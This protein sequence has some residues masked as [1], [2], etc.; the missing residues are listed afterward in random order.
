MKQ[1]TVLS[2][3]GGVGKSSIT[4][5]FAVVLSKKIK[6]LC[7]DCDVD[8][9][10]LGLVLG[11]RENDF[12][13]WNKI[14][15][16]K[17]AVIDNEK[18]ISCKLCIENCYFGAIEQR[19]NKIVVKEFGCEGCGVC[20]LV[21]PNNAVKLKDVQNGKIGTGK[22]KYGFE[23]ISGT[24]AA[25]ESGSGKIVHEIRKLASKKEN[26]DLILND[27]PAGIGCPV[28]A[29]VA[30]ANYCVIVTEPTPS[31]FSD[32]KRAFGMVSHFRIKSGLI[33]NKY[34]LNEAFTQEIEEYAKK[35]GIELIGKIQYDKSFLYAL[36]NLTPVVEYNK[37]TMPAF[38]AIAE[39]IE[40]NIK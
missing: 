4:A 15:T 35:Q 1:I 25:G 21:C 33:I 24:L 19:D 39:K 12:L 5:S 13:S 17:K 16:S 23:I 9:S 8:A 29:S 14:S 11:L 6:V 26:I 32:F 2:G 7:V 30:G 31:G 34:D 38:K 10:N 27:A 3:K 37:K 28:I 40:L 22:T 20:E 36:V 18:C